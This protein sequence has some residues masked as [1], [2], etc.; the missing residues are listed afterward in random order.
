MTR[1]TISSIIRTASPARAIALAPAALLLS[2]A[3]A[4]AEITPFE[5]A[6]IITPDGAPDDFFGASVDIDGD[7]AIVGNRWDDDAGLNT[8]SAYIYERDANGD[9]TQ[10]AKFL[11]TIVDSAAGHYAH[12]IAI[13]GDL[14]VVGAY[15]TKNESIYTGAVYVYTRNGLGVWGLSGILTPNDP[16]PSQ[17]FGRSVDLDGDHLVIGASTDS[18]NGVNSG[19]AYVFRHTGSWSQIAKL[20]PDDAAAGDNFG[21]ACAIDGTTVVIGASS[22]AGAG[23]VSGAAYV[24]TR[25]SAG[26]FGETWDQQQKLIASDGVSNDFFGFEVALDNDTAVIGAFGTGE[27]ALNNFGSAYVFERDAPNAWTQTQILSAASPEP[28]DLFGYD[29][30][31][32]GDTILVSALHDNDNAGSATVFRRDAGAWTAD[33]LIEASDAVAGDEF[34]Y[35][36]ALSNGHAIIGAPRTDDMGS[37]AGSSYIFELNACPADIN[38]DNA[39]DTAD[40]G[41]LIGAF[42]A[43]NALADINA[44]GIVDTADLGILVGAFGPCQ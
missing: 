31:I 13:S 23:P 28:A 33:A 32:D 37:S 4:T 36:I 19:S 35:A 11:P 30:A 8:G 24:F 16:I 34:G 43:D 42:N 21:I 15:A 44:D 14:A 5:I 38:G 39:V 6:E 12:D 18:P 22:N 40:L 1:R 3:A 17:G 25:T 41:I 10:V 7:R 29:A 9:W 26:P 2:A 27:F 20:V